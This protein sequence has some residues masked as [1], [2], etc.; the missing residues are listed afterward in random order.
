M[1]YI[2]YLVR[3]GEGGIRTPGTVART[4]HFECGAI[5]HSATCPQHTSRIVQR[6]AAERNENKHGPLAKS[7]EDPGLS[8]R[9]YMSL[10]MLDKKKL[11]HGGYAASH[12]V[13]AH[14]RAAAVFLSGKPGRAGQA[15]SAAG[16]N[17]GDTGLSGR[18]ELD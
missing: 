17:H 5:D 18:R 11:R 2:R 8:A 6:N 15:G 1:I 10:G 9:F 14:P 4:P 12:H 16:Q 7:T 13:G 3:G